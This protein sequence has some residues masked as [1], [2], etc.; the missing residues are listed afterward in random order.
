MIGNSVVGV[1]VYVCVCVCSCVRACV[2]ARVRACVRASVCVRET[3]CVCVS[4]FG[5]SLYRLKER[6]EV[7]FALNLIPGHHFTMF[8]TSLYSD[9]RTKEASQKRI[10]EFYVPIQHI[11]KAFVCGYPRGTGKGF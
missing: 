8:S 11:F 6:P 1:C 4:M 3:F 7:S 2:R 5:T 10:C 9:I